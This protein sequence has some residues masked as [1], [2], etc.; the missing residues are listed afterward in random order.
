MRLTDDEIR[1]IANGESELMGLMKNSTTKQIQRHIPAVIESGQRIPEKRVLIGVGIVSAIAVGAVVITNAI[2][3]KKRKSEEKARQLA[4]GYNVALH[5]YV[6]EARTG[7][8]SFA[9]I[10]DFADYISTI[11]KSSPSKD[12]QLE[13]S[14]EEVDVLRKIMRRFTKK[15][16]KANNQK[17]PKKL[18]IEDKEKSLTARQKIEEIRN[19]LLVQQKI[20]KKGK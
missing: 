6:E 17:I 10:K 20:Y 15:L 18:A 12:I 2:R 3:R 9:G 7:T 13:L 5:N 8:L 11:L 16:C 1:K 19:C 14:S 4:Q